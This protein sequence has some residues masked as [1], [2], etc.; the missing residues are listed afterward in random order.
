M[1]DG[2]SHGSE[3]NRTKA[4]NRYT[5]M[6][7][8]ELPLSELDISNTYFKIFVSVLAGLLY[9]GLTLSSAKSNHSCVD[10]HNLLTQTSMLIVYFK[11]FD[12]IGRYAASKASLS[13][14]MDVR[15][16]YSYQFVVIFTTSVISLKSLQTHPLECRVHMRT[17]LITY[18]R[19]AMKLY[20]KVQEM[21]AVVVVVVSLS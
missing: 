16:H 9:I 1:L 11:K 17:D 7:Y 20:D 12:T 8:W 2:L 3:A 4:W 6:T 15:S 10:A 14:W 13:L 5:L 18:H 19:V 21:T